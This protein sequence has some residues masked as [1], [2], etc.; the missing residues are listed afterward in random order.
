MDLD[1]EWD[2]LRSSATGSGLV[3]RPG[4]QPEPILPV[5][6]DSAGIS[7]ASGEDCGSG[8]GSAGV[9]CP[10]GVGAEGME[11]VKR[12]Y[13]PSVIIRKRRH[14]FLARLRTA[15]GRRVLVRRKAKGRW[16]QSA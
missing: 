7:D 16:K 8:S 15:G 3:P 2:Q 1:D 9:D 5:P 10:S 13:Q 4:W 14:G 6:S 12:T 11:C